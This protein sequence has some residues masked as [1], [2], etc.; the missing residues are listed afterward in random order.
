MEIA[1]SHCFKLDEGPHLDPRYHSDRFSFGR[2]P[3]DLAL[4]EG[5]ER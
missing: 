4:M 5:L 3:R 1:E 2:P